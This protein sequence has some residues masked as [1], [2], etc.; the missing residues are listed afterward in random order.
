MNILF[1]TYYVAENIKVPLGQ[2]DGS[3]IRHFQH[4]VLSLIFPN[5]PQ[6]II[7]SK[8]VIVFL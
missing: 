1:L 7:T 4:H 5:G 6:A 2:T 3:N 8:S